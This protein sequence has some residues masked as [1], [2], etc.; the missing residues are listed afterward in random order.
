MARA[1]MDRIAC[2]YIRDIMIA[3]RIHHCII[4][5]TRP[6]IATGDLSPLLL[7]T[8]R[9]CVCVCVTSAQC[10]L[11]VRISGIVIML[12]GVAAAAALF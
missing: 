2:T 4:Y 6:S 11:G 12:H 10:R 8:M 7:Y 9:V 5:Y 1:Y 3:P